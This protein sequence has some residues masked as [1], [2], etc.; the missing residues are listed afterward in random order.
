MTD[1][2]ACAIEGSIRLLPSPKPV[3]P[4]S[5]I[6][7]NRSKDITR[8]VYFQGAISRGLW[9]FIYYRLT[10]ASGWLLLVTLMFLGYGLNTLDQQAYTILAYLLC[11]WIVTVASAIWARP[12]VQLSVQSADRVSV[13]MTL[14][15]D[16]Q[17]TQLRR[18]RQDLSIIPHRL[19]PPLD[20]APEDGVRLTGLGI[21]ESA[22]ATLGLVCAERGVHHWHGFR[23]ETDFP[24]GLFRAYCTLP[25][26]HSVLVTPSFTP[27]TRLHVPTGRRYQP[28]GVA[29]AS[30]IGDS[31]E[32]IGNRE[33]REGDNL[34]D[35]DWRA[36]ARLNR[37]IV[38]EYREEYFLRVGVVLDTYLP[39]NSSD[40]DRANFERAVSITAAVSD[41]MARSDYIVDIFAAGPNLYH[42]TA[43]RSIAYLDK[44]LEILACVEGNPQEPFEEIEPEILESLAQI[45]SVICVLLDWDERRIQFVNDLASSGTGIKVIVVRDKPCTMDPAATS[46]S[47]GIHLV[48]R[49]QFSAGLAVL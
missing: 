43:G 18:W 27:L 32:F 19:P 48:T 41:Y 34:R 25:G 23:V 36:T 37:P 46:F 24:F 1:A 7:R 44:I 21:G 11:I 6:P 13:G 26:T 5:T 33:Y 30:Q 40:D 2:G 49:S 39:K 28:G 12:R 14:S 10:S 38:R 35:M 20:V 31:F 9:R 45:T 8:Y 42:L 17:V 22:R 4:P 29:M 16:L 3:Y 47:D 15:V